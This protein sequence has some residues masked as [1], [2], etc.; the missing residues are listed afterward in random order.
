MERVPRGARSIVRVHRVEPTVDIT[1]GA[2]KAIDAAHSRTA[3]SCHDESDTTC[4]IAGLRGVRPA[5][6]VAAQST[7]GDNERADAGT[8]ANR[9]DNATGCRSNKR[10]RAHGSR[11]A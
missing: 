1:F 9:A 7:A 3:A 4:G 8:A 11:I 5:A 6:R 2:K 10:Q